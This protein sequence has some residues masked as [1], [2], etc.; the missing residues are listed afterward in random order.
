MPKQR[1]KVH[2]GNIFKNNSETPLL[3]RMCVKTQVN[4]HMDFFRKGYEIRELE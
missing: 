3:M 2:F 4:S 1:I